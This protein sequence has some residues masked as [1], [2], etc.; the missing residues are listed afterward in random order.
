MNFKQF[1]YSKINRSKLI[2]WHLNKS[3]FFV[4]QKACNSRD[5]STSHQMYFTQKIIS[6]SY[7]FQYDVNPSKISMK[8]SVFNKMIW[9]S[10][11]TYS[12]HKMMLSLSLCSAIQKLSIHCYDGVCNMTTKWLFHIIPLGHT[13]FLCA[14]YAIKVNACGNECDPNKTL[15]TAYKYVWKKKGGERR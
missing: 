6:G 5:F 3:F 8:P 9:C 11:L 13:I 1:F 7:L 2:F 14:N 4:E 10:K 15:V 12:Y